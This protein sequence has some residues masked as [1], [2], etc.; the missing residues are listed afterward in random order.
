MFKP[1]KVI[2]MRLSEDL[3]QNL[4]WFKTEYYRFNRTEVVTAIVEKALHDIDKRTLL[5]FLYSMYYKDQWVMT[6]RKKPLNPPYASQDG[7]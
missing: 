2:T 1:K 4:D 5:N 3:L 7:V 6:I